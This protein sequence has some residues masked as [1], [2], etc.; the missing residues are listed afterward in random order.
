MEFRLVPKDDGMGYMVSLI[1]SRDFG[2]GFQKFW[3]D[4]LIKKVNKYGEG[5]HYHDKEAAI[6]AL[7]RT[8]K[9]NIV[10]DPFVRTFEYGHGATKEGYWTYD[11]MVCQAEDCIDVLTCVFQTQFDYCILLDHSQGHDRKKPNGL[12]IDSM[13]KSF[14][15]ANEHMR[16]CDPFLQQNMGPFQ[17]PNGPP[18][19][20]VN[21]QQILWWDPKYYSSEDCGPFH[22]SKQERLLRRNDVLLGTFK[23][24]NKTTKELIT[25]LKAKGLEPRGLLKALQEMA[26]GNGIAIKK[27]VQKVREGWMGKN[28][29]ILQV[30][31]ERRWIDISKLDQ[32]RMDPVKDNNGNIIDDTYSLKMIM[33]RQTDFQNEK[34]LLQHN[35]AEIG[36][37]RRINI[38][39]LRSPKCHPE[40][41]GE[42]VE[43]FIA[44]AKLFIRTIPWQNRKNIRTFQKYVMLAFSRSVG[45]KITDDRAI[46]FSRRAR[47]Y[48]VAYYILHGCG[49]RGDSMS[50]E[51][52]FKKH[53][54]LS[55]QKNT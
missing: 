48:I 32:Y 41:A 21:D 14:S 36:S 55:Q 19:L 52:L 43:Y 53:C 50:V 16:D 35:V 17:Y 38:S 13:T 10:T 49:V 46:A 24:K 29:G 22:F 51:D 37:N 15:S 8:S 25:E 11:H 26:V 42:G 28:K 2:I 47:D 44:H 6:A 5:Q 33:E 4:D 40:V 23:E 54:N 30:L 18:Q 20:K 9:N 3:N 12:N 1:V 31:Y 34:T 39:I 7:K 27:N 45:S